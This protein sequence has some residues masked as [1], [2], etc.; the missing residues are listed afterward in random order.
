MPSSEADTDLLLDRVRHGD[1]GARRRLL[2][3]H[4]GRLRRAV[5][6]RL[7]RRLAA[8]VDPSD[9]VQDVLAEADRRLDDYAVRRPLPYYPW[10]RQLAD[11]RLAALYRRHVRAKRR[12]VDCE[13]AIPAPLSSES[14]AALAER[15]VDR[16]SRPG[17]RIVREELRQRVHA[18]L[19][20]LPEKDRTVLVLRHL[21]QRP[22]AEVA[23]RLGI[24]EGAVR[25]RVVRALA[26]LAS[27]WPTCSGRTSY[28]SNRASD[29]QRRR[30]GCPA[31]RLWPA[32]SRPAMRSISRRSCATTRTTPTNYG[33]PAAG[34][35]ASWPTWPS[36]GGAR[37]TPA[38]ARRSASWATSGSSARSA[39]AAWAW[40]TRRSRSRCSR[41]VAL[42]VLPFAATMDP[43]HLQRFQN[44]ARAAASLH[45]DAHRAGLRAS[46]ASGACTTTPCSSS[47]GRRW[48]ELIPEL[49]RENAVDHGGTVRH[50]R[51]NRHG[52]SRSLLRALRVAAAENSSAASPS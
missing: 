32:A 22:T 44:E 45:H 9:V 15:L 23:E 35:A 34:L 14:V 50:G 16:G 1:A 49:K 7:D 25:V 46:A 39:G 21:E 42:K 17:S 37:F 12:T 28:D 36:S 30:V 8:R 5:A 10:L 48:R 41:R 33:E 40:S 4:R 2:D 24:S 18:A 38:T 51:R 52:A 29:R 47:T 43:K 11:E 31:R 13:E 26:R 3:R 19:D 27:C 6:R 20:R